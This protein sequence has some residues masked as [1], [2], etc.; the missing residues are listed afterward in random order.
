MQIW[1]FIE[2]ETE[3]FPPLLN[4]SPDYREKNPHFHCLISKTLIGN[5]VHA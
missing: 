2:G 3:V 5:Q 4:I 1:Q